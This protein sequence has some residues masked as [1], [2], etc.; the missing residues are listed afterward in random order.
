LGVRTYLRQVLYG[1]GA[2]L[3]LAILWGLEVVRDAYFRLLDR[4]NVKPRRRRGS[5][6][7]PGQPRR[8]HD[9]A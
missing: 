7:P 2:T 5:A 1:V 3:G 6:F 8:R 9:A 4:L